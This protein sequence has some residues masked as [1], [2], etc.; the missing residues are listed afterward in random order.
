M[1]ETLQTPDPQ[2][3]IPGAF[4]PRCG[5]ECYAP[6]YTCIRCERRFIDDTDGTE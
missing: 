1:P 3:A 2:A 4:C 6:T 5:S